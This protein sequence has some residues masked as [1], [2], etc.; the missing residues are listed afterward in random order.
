MSVPTRQAPPTTPPETVELWEDSRIAIWQDYHLSGIADVIGA[1][2]LGQALMALAESG[3]LDRLRAQSVTPIDGAVAGLD[4]Q[5]ARGLL[6][7]LELRGVVSLWGGDVLL[8][9]RGRLLTADAAL[10][11]LGFYLR[12]YGPVTSR[13]TELVTGAARYGVDVSRSGAALGRH[14]G[15]VSTSA[16][17]SVV[18]HA[19]E[20]RGASTLVDLGCG[21]GALVVETCLRQ[22]QLR[23]TGIDL[24]SDAIDDARQ[25]AEQHGVADRVRFVVGDAFAPGTWD[26][27]CRGTDVVC[28]VGV[29]HERFRDGEQAVVDVLD[30]YAGMMTDEAV[31]LIGEPELRYDDRE[32]DSDF[33]LVHVLTAQGIPRDRT[34]WLPLFERS[35]LRCARYYVNAVAGPRTVFYELERR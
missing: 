18:L 33:Y 3:M 23:A 25:L 29:L 34:G 17:T 4:Q 13:M 2:H 7:Y 28:G 27:S 6:R 35:A 14:S 26:D 5:A 19:L 11:R 21:G 8:T 9:A 10:A 20:T 32:N 15:T 31:V 22:P 12:A 30:R 1:T 16:Y 24:S